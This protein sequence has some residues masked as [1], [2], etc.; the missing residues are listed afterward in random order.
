MQ[1]SEPTSALWTQDESLRK[2]RSRLATLPEDIRVVSFDFFDTLICRLCAEPS[3]LFIEVGRRLADAKLLRRP[4]SPE[5]F[6]DARVA[7]DDQARR[8][9]TSCGRSPEITLS[10]IY[11]ELGAVVNNTA[12]ACRVEW[13]TERHFCFLNPS[14]ASLVKHVRSLGLKVALISDTY[15][16]KAE[17]CQFLTDNGFSPALFDHLFVSNEAGCA[18]WDGRLFL[19][20]CEHFNIHPNE[21]L[22]LGDNP[23]ADVKVAA[24]FGVQTVYYH[25]ATPREADTFARERALNAP[26]PR[27]AASI[28]ALRVLTARLAQ[29]EADAFRDGAS[30]FGPVLSLYADWCVRRFQAAGVKTVLAL[31]REG[32][33]LGELVE[34]AARAAHVELKIQPCFVSRLSTA[35]ASV[36]EVTP[37]T[38]AG[39]LEGSP[40]LTLYNVLEIL[41]V[42]NDAQGLLPPEVLHKQVPSAMAMRPLLERLMGQKRLVELI[43]R[44]CKESHALAFEYLNGLTG[45][46]A[47]IG[48][49][50]LGWSG[51]IQRNVLRILRNG[52]R[53]VC[54]VG[55][56]VATTRRAGRLGLDGDAAH[57]FLDSDWRR[58]TILAEVAIN[59]CLGSTDGYT[60]TAD[61]QVVPVLGNYAV[62]EAERQLKQ[63]IREGILAFQAFWLTVCETRNAITPAMRADLEQ[64]A[65]AQLIRLIEHPG[66]AEAR[67]LGDLTHDE[68]YWDHQYTRPLCSAEA[69]E[70]VVSGGVSQL[71]TEFRCHWPQGV[72]A[73]RHPRL[74][75]T[76][77]KQ[78]ADAPALGRAGCTRN[79]AGRDT[80]LTD[81]ER[82]SLVA[83]L[84]QFRPHQVV[85]AS[86][87]AAAMEDDFAALATSNV[88]SGNSTTPEGNAGPDPR[89]YV[90]DYEESCAQTSPALISFSEAPA[91]VDWHRRVEGELTSPA[92]MRT[93][94]GAL[95]S[96]ARHALVLTG[97]FSDGTT[98]ALLNSLT[99]FLGAK[100]II[101]ARC[102]D[103]DL[104]DARENPLA[105]VLSQWLRAQGRDLG[106][107]TWQPTNNEIP[108]RRNWIVLE[109]GVKP[110]ESE[111]YWQLTL[112][113]L[114]LGARLGGQLWQPSTVPNLGSVTAS[115][116]DERSGKEFTAS[117]RR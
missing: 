80:R 101:L 57:A 23:N 85:F 92:T 53:K 19:K 69:E 83:L 49:I 7:A 95:Q 107:D 113:D 64:Q 22:H 115:R 24:Q 87:G 40:T 71:F 58:G 110:R 109:R 11:E 82:A 67:R 106:F 59:A 105:T 96:A 3:D 112:T 55:C 52:G 88:S 103:S 51:S 1:A 26:A 20:A 29:D 66:P 8:L 34:R 114:P 116:S 27:R 10:A 46:D 28:N 72:V 13:E 79:A 36:T 75:A 117:E 41:G 74:V 25:K 98:T 2:L 33:L 21:L 4:L 5:E 99:P 56:Y 14:I 16:T 86:R 100:G 38:V 81:E 43:T 70:C 94:R 39:L 45:G 18:K 17:L 111:D 50:D 6:H 30:V 60:R 44:R 61:G 47:T 97:E 89:T 104:V 108:L 78:W 12:A 35:R 32:E 84:R 77:N 68:N 54:G 31:M 73:R 9:A 90:R 15:F 62:S 37:A 65:A 93:T 91:R 42:L 63:R 48:F 102:G 76:L